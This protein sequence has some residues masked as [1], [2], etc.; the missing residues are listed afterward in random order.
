MG[1]ATLIVCTLGLLAGCWLLWRIP[2]PA[3]VAGSLDDVAVVIPARDEEWSLP[4]LLDS[5]RDQWPA[6]VVVVDDHS[7][8]GTAGVAEAYGATLI[9]APDLP[10]GWTGKAWACWS[11]AQAATAPTLVFVDADTRFH[12][13]GL[14]K[15]VGELGRTGGLVAVQPFH[16]PKHQY[17][18]LAALFNVVAMMGVDAFTPLQHRLAPTGAFGPCLTTTR[19]DYDASGGHSA[20][21][22]EVVE[23]V[24]L[25]RRYAGAGMPVTCFGGRGVVDFRMYP[26]GVAQLVE[27]FTKNF[28]RGAAG[29][30]PVTLVLVVLWITG[31]LLAVGAVR[32]LS[33]IGLAPYAAYV[34]QL[35]WMLRRIGR[36]GWWPPL[37]Y[38]VP[39][40]FFIAVFGRS[41][42]L[43][44]VRKEVTWRGRT[45]RT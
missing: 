41:L 40:V 30:R 7:A 24:A 9:E 11:G 42:V 14:A 21:R 32:R 19:S 29:A 6:E 8:D 4:V 25:S 35:V 38:P 36:F 27:G 20:V 2:S 10:P 23:D 17:E 22:G 18:R 34:V 12:P 31:A 5:L 15:V 37:L 16:T 44:Y 39:L 26:G 43:T 1:T 33:P 3:G 13:G 28:G 45:I